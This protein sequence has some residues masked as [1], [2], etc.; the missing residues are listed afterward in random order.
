MSIRY[1]TGRAAAL[2]P[3]LYEELRAALNEGGDQPLIVLVPEQYTLQS[4]REIVTAL[5]LEGSFRLQVI[6]PA[7]L[8]SRIFAEVGKPIETRIDERGRVMLMHAALK[9]LTRDLNWYRGAQHRSGFAERAAGQIAELKQAGYTPDRLNMLSESLPVGPLK[10]KLG[11]LVLIWNAYEEAL[12][13]RY[14]DGED[15]LNRALSRLDRAPFLQ[16]ARIWANGFELVS[17]TLACTLT[18][19]AAAHDTALLLP[20]EMDTGAGDYD[21]FEPVRRSFARL[22]RM[23]ADANITQQTVLLSEPPEKQSE[24]THLRREINCITPR[25]WDALPR[26]IRLV[27][28]R[29]PL[30]EAMLVMATIRSRVMD[31]KIRWRDAAIACFDLPTYDDALRR[32]AAL[33]EVPVFL[34]S[35][36]GSD[37]NALARFVTLHLRIVSANWQTEDVIALMRTG[38]T[39]LTDEEADCLANAAIEQ[40][41][42]GAL[43]KKPL[44]RYQDERDAQ[45]EPLRLKL[46]EPVMR[47]E[48]EFIEAEN[49]KAQMTALWNLLERAGA[50]DK[51]SLFEESCAQSGL[52]EAANENAQV[53]NRLITTLDQMTSLMADTSLSARDVSEMITQ[54]LAASD[55]KPLPQSGDAVMIGSL[56]HLRGEAVDTLFIMGCNEMHASAQSGLFQTRER[57]LLGGEKGVWLAPDASDRTR[58]SAIDLSAT[59]AMAHRFVLFTYALSDAEG[60]A[61]MPGSVVGRLRAVFPALRD[62]GGLAEAGNTERLM[63]NAPDAAL[64]QLSGALSSGNLTDTQ[65]E[66]FA[67]LSRLGTNSFEIENLRK[68]ASARVFS[69]DIDRATAKRLYGGPTSVSVT[70]LEK[71]AACP[72][73]HFVQYGLRPEKLEPYALSKADEGT[74]YHAAMEDFLRNMGT[75]GMNAEEAVERMDAVSERL[76][77]PM[78]DGPLGDNPVMLAHSRRMRMI[79][80]RA[81]RTA[82]R[83]LSQSGFEPFALEVKFGEYAPAVVLHTSSGN[84]PVQ[85][86]IDRID[87]WNDQDET[88]LRVIDYKSGMSE[89]NLSRLYFGLQLQLIIYLAAALGHGENH[90]AGAFYFKVADPVVESPSRDPDVVE[91][92]RVKELRLS[93]LYIN[94]QAVLKAMSPGVDKIVNLTLKSDGTP[95]SST[96]MLDEDGFALLIRYAIEAAARMTDEIIAGK[97]GIDPKKMSGFCS[98]DKCDWKNICQQD[99]LLGGMPRTLTPAVKQKEVLGLIREQLDEEAG[100]EE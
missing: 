72:F 82:T 12:A 52:W 79:A 50:H 54:S 11:D 6:S 2:K 8:Y 36:R 57:E 97:T 98:C 91:G 18:S 31:G 21:T 90:P 17:P 44:H 65:R 3:R 5:S 42:R 74:F 49:T 70:R 30:D 88:W 78:M 51:L 80:R 63:L 81:A 22:C 4:E 29:N 69:A 48:E 9:G 73:M 35:G 93:G 37:R 41:L 15:E 32:A 75:G 92:E 43:W 86:R 34:E 68:A 28:R 20:L 64:V 46:V 38:Y 94:D 61:V 10:A 33:Y 100:I 25:I 40:G 53:W 19:L 95:Q 67:S 85:G 66:A 16:N 59:L 96:S 24:L 60:A 39:E 56:N 7:R 47:F 27:S 71:Y 84:V 13:G 83:Q 1:L 14:M 77:A 45:L 26:C 55:I 99:P 62:S 76:L 89:L 23:M 87:C 58:L